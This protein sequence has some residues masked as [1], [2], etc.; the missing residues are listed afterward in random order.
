MINDWSK[1][2]VRVRVRPVSLS[3]FFQSFAY[4]AMTTNQQC[5]TTQ[6]TTMTMSVPL[7]DTC[8]LRVQ[9][10]LSS[11]TFIPFLLSPFSFFNLTH[12]LHHS[13][14][15]KLS[16]FASSSSSKLLFLHYINWCYI[17][18]IKL[19]KLNWQIGDM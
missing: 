18:Y 4:K 14:C 9:L 17:V 11:S 3:L 8:A 10:P 6:V 2:D 13:L 5:T 12:L 15:F 19:I 7:L 16:T 1:E